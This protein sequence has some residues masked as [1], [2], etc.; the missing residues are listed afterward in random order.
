MRVDS[1][2]FGEFSDISVGFSDAVL[3]LVSLAGFCFLGYTIFNIIMLR[4]KTREE[5]EKEETEAENKSDYETRLIHANVANLSRAERRARARA[6]VK[7]QLRVQAPRPHEHRQQGDEGD[8]LLQDNGGEQE[9]LVPVVGGGL[10]EMGDENETLPSRLSRRE[11][12]KLAKVLQKQERKVMEEQRRKDQKQVEE[13]AQKEKREREKRL[14]AQIDNDR[15]EQ[16]ILQQEEHKKRLE[17][18]N[19]FLSSDS[20]TLSLEQWILELR[21]NRV[22][23]IDDVAVRFQ[24]SSSSVICRIQELVDQGRIAGIIN[25]EGQFVYISEDEIKE[26]A[27]R[28]RLRGVATRSDVAAICEEVVN[29]HVE[30]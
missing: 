22:V 15:R 7:Q 17:A 26:I 13:A 12:Q 18:Y 24:R 20:Y 9:Q 30:N 27:E 5:V 4:L 2:P 11:R 29:Q 21:V 10:Q 6:I 25:S 28:V 19:T 14:A 16:L 1:S 8:P 23:S 3:V